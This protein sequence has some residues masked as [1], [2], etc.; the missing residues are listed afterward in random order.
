MNAAI[1]FRFYNSNQPS[2]CHR[3]QFSTK[4]HS[5]V[6]VK[7]TSGFIKSTE[8]FMFM[9]L[10]TGLCYWIYAERTLKLLFIKVQGHSAL[11]NLLNAL[12]PVQ[13]GGRVDA[14]VESSTNTRRVYSGVDGR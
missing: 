5:F 9:L 3:S 4:L 11:K 13:L 10:F 12:L 6:S 1:V 8:S 2:F 7:S 14:L